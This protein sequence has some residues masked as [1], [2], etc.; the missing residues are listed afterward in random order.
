MFAGT[1]IWWL[2]EDG[3]AAKIMVSITKEREN[4]ISIQNFQLSEQWSRNVLDV[5]VLDLEQ[6][7]LGHLLGLLNT[8]L[9]LRHA[10][11]QSKPRAFTKGP[12][13]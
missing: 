12:M 10:F 8:F 13:C 4:Q 5:L 11:I 2:N 7:L 6:T 9:S 1:I 3:F